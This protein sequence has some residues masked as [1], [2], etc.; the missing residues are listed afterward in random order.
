MNARELIQH[1]TGLNLSAAVAERAVAERLARLGQDDAAAY[2]ATIAPAEI[3]AL[4]E[5]VVVP[6]SWMFRDPE[7]FVAVAAFVRERLAAHP[8]RIVRILSIPC[9][10]GEEPYSIAMALSDAA[11]PRTATLIDAIDLSEV[12]LE[13]ARL[14]RY[15]RNAFRGAELGFRERHFTQDGNE[16]QIAQALREQVN[17][18]Q[19]NLLA[20]D[21]G[22]NAGRYDI[23][24]CRNLLIYFDDATTAAAIARLRLLLADDGML[25]AGYAEVPSFCA[26]GFAPLRVPG[27]FALQKERRARLRSAPK[28]APPAPPPRARP[29]A[30][31]PRVA[32]RAAPPAP[33]VAAPD[34][35]ALLERAGRLAD[36]GD[37]QGAAQLCHA[38][39]KT[40]PDSAQ[41]Y[42][43]LGMI[44]ECENKPGVADDY[45]RRCVYLQPDHYDA[46]CHL[47][48]LAERR[49]D[50]AQ[51]GVFKQR[52][53]R[54]YE[55]RADAATRKSP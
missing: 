47:A 15:T 44:S 53:A 36:Q 1:A 20:I 18:S 4:T 46:L 16:Y 12:A 38:L 14:G 34:P 6:E 33:A 43:I 30:A 22:A 41:A 48:L 25:L 40:A 55:R 51:A 49:G 11:V 24:F 21:T 31:A 27:A 45:W 23:V 29:P 17:F 50:A 32:P 39:L 13:R 2:L 3:K 28:E 19:G 35:G 42:F 37:V 9:A 10:G 54:V 52:A 7:A 26:N 8:A 5:L